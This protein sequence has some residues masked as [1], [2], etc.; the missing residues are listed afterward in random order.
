M[1]ASQYQQI[2][3]EELAVSDEPTAATT[4]AAEDNQPVAEEKP[5]TLD[6]ENQ[7]SSDEHQTEAPGNDTE[8]EVMKSTSQVCVPLVVLPPWSFEITSLVWFAV[9]FGFDFS[10]AVRVL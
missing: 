5:N 8:P 3:E 1:S 6:P 10:V 7:P 4:G 9:I 2:S